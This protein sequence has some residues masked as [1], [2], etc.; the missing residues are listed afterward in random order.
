MDLREIARM[1]MG[2]PPAE[3]A[4][5]M[6]S[7]IMGFDR[8]LGLRFVTV[9]GAEVVAEV[10]VTDRHV[11][12][13]GLVHGGVYATIGESV[14]S[15]GAAFS[16]MAE[17]KN[18]VGAENTTRFHRGCRPGTTLTAIA[19]PMEGARSASQRVWEAVITDGAGRRCAT[20]RVTIA[21]LEPGRR[22]AGEDVGLVGSLTGEQKKSE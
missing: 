11:Q 14:C 8:L 13:Y 21:V 17:G 5:L 15:V 19:R 6:N 9:D 18:A 16:V 1:M 4:A 2:L 3:R 20:S 12:P 10:A 7:G 22:I